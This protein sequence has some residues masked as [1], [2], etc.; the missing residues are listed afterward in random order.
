M[1]AG[2]K[3]LDDH[4]AETLI[5]RIE[6]FTP[7][8]KL[9][10]YDVIARAAET[11]SSAQN[12]GAD[13]DDLMTFLDELGITLARNTVRNYLSRALAEQRNSKNSADAGRATRTRST[14]EQPEN[15]AASAAP[16][17]HSCA[18]AADEHHSP[19]ANS[20]NSS[21]TLDTAAAVTTP[22]PSPSLSVLERARA[23]ALESNRSNDLPT[24]GSFRIRPDTKDL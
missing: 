24:P 7:R 21:E 8:P 16:A 13:I 23:H 1:S 10:P 17:T 11:F 18:P 4:A 12:R 15:K 6:Q 20:A 22:T 19:T 3:K 2:M 9:R 14:R 5:T